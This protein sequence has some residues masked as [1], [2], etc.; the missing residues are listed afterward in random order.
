[1]A[2]ISLGFLIYAQFNSGYK[3]GQAK[4]NSLMYLYDADLRKAVWATYDRN[5]DDWTRTYLKNIVPPGKDLKVD[6]P[7][8]TYISTAPLKKLQ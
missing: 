2:A 5:L 8:L 6:H 3:S 4:P 7:Q 1:M